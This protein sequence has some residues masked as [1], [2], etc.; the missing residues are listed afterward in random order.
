MPA[1]VV[2]KIGREGTP[3]TSP[4]M[5][6]A[7]AFGLECRTQCPPPTSLERGID[8]GAHKVIFVDSLFWG[9]ARRFVVI[10]EELPSA[11]ERLGWGTRRPQR[12]YLKPPQSLACLEATSAAGKEGWPVRALLCVSVTVSL[13]LHLQSS[14]L[15]QRPNQGVRRAWLTKVQGV[16][17]YR[18]GRL[19]L[20]KVSV[21]ADHCCWFGGV[22]SHPGE[23]CGFRLAFGRLYHTCS[24]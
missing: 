18:R 8:V 23:E 13:G 9:C 7:D 11:G 12:G 2:A 3:G 10:N 20:A 16:T 1:P 15:F 14:L 22:M 4:P 17:G 6:P 21:A 19:C 24:H 5:A